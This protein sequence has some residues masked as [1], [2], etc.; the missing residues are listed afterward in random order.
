MQNNCLRIKKAN[1]LLQNCCFKKKKHSFS[2][3]L[4]S[5]FHEFIKHIIIALVNFQVGEKDHWEIQA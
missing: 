4:T 5:S 3:S 2:Q 1:Y